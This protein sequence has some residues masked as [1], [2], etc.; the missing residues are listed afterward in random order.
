MKDESLAIIG[1]TI[2]TIIVSTIA[3]GTLIVLQHDSMRGDARDQIGALRTDMNSQFEAVRSDT[4]S[5]FAA[6]RSDTDRQI[7]TLRGDM[8]SRFGALRS[9]MNSQFE[10]VRSDIREI[11]GDIGDLSERVARI[12]VIIG[13]PVNEPEPALN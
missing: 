9:D 13:G 12:E 3:I 10:A 2:G 8:N 1:S 7:D 5:R 11:R 4:D 6:L